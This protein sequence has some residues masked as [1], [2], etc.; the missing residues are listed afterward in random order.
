MRSLDECK[1][2]IFRRVEDRK[3]ERRKKEAEKIRDHFES[4]P[5]SV[6]RGVFFSATGRYEYLS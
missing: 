2:E 1:A 6:Y 3:K 4:S 5:E